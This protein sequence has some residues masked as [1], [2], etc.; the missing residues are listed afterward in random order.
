MA[1]YAARTKVPAD[2][3]RLE[4]EALLPYFR[5]GSRDDC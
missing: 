2:R 1:E 4:I 3:T 5:N